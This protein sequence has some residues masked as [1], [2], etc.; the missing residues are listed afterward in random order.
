[1]CWAL[2]PCSGKNRDFP[3]LAVRSGENQRHIAGLSLSCASQIF[4]PC[5]QDEIKIFGEPFV[6]R[7]GRSDRISSLCCSSAFVSSV[8]HV[9]ALT[10]FLA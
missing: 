7:E 5:Q 1:M 10:A 9:G 8:S 4:A 2:P 6:Q 3:G